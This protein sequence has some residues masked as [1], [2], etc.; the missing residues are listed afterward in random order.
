MDK[1]E[2]K[3]KDAKMLA[4]YLKAYSR[5]ERVVAIDKIQ[6]G[7]I[8]PRSTVWNWINGLARIPELYKCKIE[9][10]FGQKIFTN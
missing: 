3:I 6:D 7:C 4:N 2:Q 1:K 8:V 9:E 5:N 10:I